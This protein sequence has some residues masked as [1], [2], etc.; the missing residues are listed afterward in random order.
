MQSSSVDLLRCFLF[1]L[2]VRLTCES[3][4]DLF[5]CRQTHS[6]HPEHK[7]LGVGVIAAS[8]KG[9]FKEDWEVIRSRVCRDID[10]FVPDSPYRV[11]VAGK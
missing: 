2:F 9:N 8:Y 7:K 5:Y 3:V 10:I 11:S 4:V 6:T 1:V